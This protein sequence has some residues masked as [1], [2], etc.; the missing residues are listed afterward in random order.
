MVTKPAFQNAIRVSVGRS[1][2]WSGVA[3][4]GRLCGASTDQPISCHAVQRGDF[5]RRVLR[6]RHS[7]AASAK[8]ATM[9]A[10]RGNI[11]A[12]LRRS[13]GAIR[14]RMPQIWLKPKTVP[15]RSPAPSTTPNIRLTLPRASGRRSHAVPANQASRPSQH[16]RHSTSSSRG[17]RRSPLATH[18]AGRGPLTLGRLRHGR[19]SRRD[20]G[21]G[22]GDRPR[23]PALLDLLHAIILS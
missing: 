7:A 5:A 3:G 10:A 9:R 12:G 18:P 21:E 23:S 11:T 22:P 6:S 20:L 17:A 1:S 13:L 16:G 15:H 14:F 2:E 4:G 8:M 19:R